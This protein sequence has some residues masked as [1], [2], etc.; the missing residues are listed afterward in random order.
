MIIGRIAVVGSTNRLDVQTQSAAKA[1]AYHLGWALATKRLPILV[2]DDKPIFVEAE[3]VRGY[4]ASGQAAVNS[5]EVRYPEKL[6]DHKRPNPPPF[7][8]YFE[9]GH[10]SF[11]FQPDRNAEWE[12]SFYQSLETIGGMVI[13]QGGSSTLIAGVIALGYNKP[14]L[15][16]SGFGGMAVKLTSVLA[17]KGAI[18]PE[19]KARLELRP[20]EAAQAWAKECVEILLKQA[21]KIESKRQQQAINVA[22]V[23]RRQTVHT[24]L[25]ASMAAIAL[26][27]CIVNWDN[28]LKFPPVGVLVVIFIVAGLSGATGAML[29]SI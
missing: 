3:V 11:L 24:L 16:C 19:E 1:A 5:I 15:S 28:S 6:D 26:I 4:L 2:Y 22:S 14:V 27:L 17:E 21:E 18:A 13:F 23:K 12:I 9:E 10:P 8:T 25:A 20:G 29:R 7:K